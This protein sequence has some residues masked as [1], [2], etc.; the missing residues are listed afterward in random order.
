MLCAVI[1]VA[2]C[3]EGGPMGDY[4][5]PPSHACDNTEG[6][7][8]LYENRLARES[9]ELFWRINTYKG[10]AVDWCL[11][12]RLVEVGSG[13]RHE[14]VRVDCCHGT[15]HRHRFRSSAPSWEEKTDLMD[16]HAGMQNEVDNMFGVEYDHLIDAW[17]QYVGR[18]R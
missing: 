1:R 9:Y 18:W 10:R 8:D 16:L 13:V 12:L 3:V 5:P 15:V 4:E 14:V 2:M 11:I 6:T 7:V 17:D